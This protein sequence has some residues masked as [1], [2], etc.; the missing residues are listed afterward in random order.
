MLDFNVSNTY[1][2]TFKI[3]SYYP[4][5][6]PQEFVFTLPHPTKVKKCYDMVTGVR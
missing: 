4:K 3:V 2:R 6:I 1:S 5:N